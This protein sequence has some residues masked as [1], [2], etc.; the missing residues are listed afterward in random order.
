MPKQR[1]H[2]GYRIELDAR[3]LEFLRSRGMVG[4]DVANQAAPAPP[5]ADPVDAARALRQQNAAK[6]Q[7]ASAF[8]KR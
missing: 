5:P 2:E 3:M 1:E 7:R 8:G 4:A 6:V